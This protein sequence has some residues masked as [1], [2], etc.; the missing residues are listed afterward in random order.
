MELVLC[1]DAHVLSE[2]LGREVSVGKITHGNNQ[3]T[4]KVKLSSLASEVP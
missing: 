2:A 1:E 4:L 3:A